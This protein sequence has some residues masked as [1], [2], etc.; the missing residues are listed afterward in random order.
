MEKCKIESS[1]CAANQFVHVKVAHKAGSFVLSL[2]AKFASV[3]G[4]GD[5]IDVFDSKVDGKHIAY[6][7]KNQLLFSVPILN[8]CDAEKA[9]KE[10]SGFR[11]FSMDR[12]FLKYSVLMAIQNN[13]IRPSFSMTANMVKLAKENQR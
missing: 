8:K 6:R 1:F 11:D 10:I 9:L 2:P 12:L 3:F 4:R 7:I 13:A 5:R